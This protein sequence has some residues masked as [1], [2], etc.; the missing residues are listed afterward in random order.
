MKIRFT[1]TLSTTRQVFRRGHEYDVE[2]A[3]ARQ[4]IGAAVAEQVP[5]PVET[6]GQDKSKR[7][8]TAAEKAAQ[9]N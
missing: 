8:L 3:T 9:S 5:A 2:D 4:Y 7:Q 1:K 6:K